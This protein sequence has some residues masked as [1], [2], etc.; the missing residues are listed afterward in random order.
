MISEEIL[1]EELKKRIF[2]KICEIQ[3]INQKTITKVGK[4]ALGANLHAV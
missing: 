1:E 2:D 4:I 3:D